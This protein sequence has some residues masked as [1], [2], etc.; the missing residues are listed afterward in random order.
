MVEGEHWLAGCPLTSICAPWYKYTHAT[1]T[2][3]KNIIIY[4]IYM[5]FLRNHAGVFQQMS[6]LKFS[7]IY[8]FIFYIIYM[9][10][11]WCSFIV[12]GSFFFLRR[13]SFCLFLLVCGGGGSG[14]PGTCSVDQAGFKLTELH[15]GLKVCTHPLHL[16]HVPSRHF[17]FYT[18][19]SLAAP[20]PCSGA[21]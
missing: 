21:H 12:F 2:T 6:A 9:G 8:L 18:H 4:L 1:T 15:L 17:H 10:P 16:A 19:H 5:C 11:K 13:V 3:N 14:C 20:P 7:F